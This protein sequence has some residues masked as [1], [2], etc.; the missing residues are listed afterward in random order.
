MSHSK[1]NPGQVRV[2]KLSENHIL[3]SFDC[4][5]KDLNDFLKNDAL[6]Y[7]IQLIAK[8]FIVFYNEQIIC[9]FSVLNDSIKLKF[10]ETE[11][12]QKLKRLHEYPALKIGRLGVDNAFKRKGIGKIVINFV[13][14]L[15]K[16][17]NHISACRFVSVDSYPNSV[18]FYAKEGFVKNQMYEKKKDFISM[19][20]DIINLI[21]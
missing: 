4:G 16:Y 19:R 2:V 17:T 9:F 11:E 7:N 3:D 5:D 8:T 1:I 6:G 12:I 15:T 21:K 18:L 20:L 14:G 13:V 10:D